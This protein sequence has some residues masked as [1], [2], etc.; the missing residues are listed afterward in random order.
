LDL[1]YNR[2]PLVSRTSSDL[3]DCIHFAV[4]LDPSEARWRGELFATKEP[5][6][7]LVEQILAGNPRAEEQLVSAFQQGVF[8][9]ATART[10]DRE[11]ARDLSQE[12]MIAVLKAVRGGQLRDPEKLAAFVHGTTRNL[13]SNYL[14]RRAERFETDLESC[15][16]PAIDPIQNLEQAE[17]RRMMLRELEALD[18]IDQLI[19]LLSLVDGYT[20]AEVAAKLKISHDA[21]RAR[22]SRALRKIKNKFVV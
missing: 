6:V 8:L 18:L 19:L 22:R 4:S 15:A 1:G 2:T 11:A 13:V 16:E 9:I 10:R 14:R 17:R 20:L 21:V 12:V 7:N 3:T 5:T